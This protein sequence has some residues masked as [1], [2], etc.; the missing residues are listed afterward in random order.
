MTV[1]KEEKTVCRKCGSDRLRQDTDTLDTWFS[2]A[3]WPF[4]TLGWPDK[5][6]DFDYFYPTDTLVTAYEIIFFWVVRMMFSGLEHTGEVPFKTVFIHGLF[7]DS[8]GRKMSKSL[9][10]GIDPL[11]VIDQYGADALRFM[12]ASGNSPG[13]DMR[14][15]E[16]KVR[17]ARGFANKLWNAAR[18]IIM[19]L[20]ENLNTDLGGIALT[21][22]DKW[23]ISKLNALIKEVTENLEKFELGI[24]AGKLYDFIWD[25]Y[26]DWYIELTKPRL[27]NDR[28]N[29]CAVLLRVMKDM[30]KLLHP[31]MPFITEEIWQ[32]LTGGDS[33]LMLEPFP[34][35][36]AEMSFAQEEND[37]SKIVDLIKS[38]RNMRSQM[39]IPPSVKTNL[40]VET[41]HTEL[42]NS[43]IML[44]ER[45]AYAK[46]VKIVTS[47]ANTDGSAVC[48]TDSARAFIPM[49]ELTDREKELE[50]LNREKDSVQKDIDFLTQ[51]L[52]NENFIAKAP[53]HL[54]DAEKA[55]LKKAQ[56]RMENILLSMKGTQ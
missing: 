1:T 42:F 11:D 25:I 4:S 21:A 28:E 20:P 36:D 19:N 49:T 53:P 29:A 2:S 18:Y 15:S 51:K 37:F 50:R 22:E 52:G 32:S 33:V 6:E 10:N 34:V 39:N 14:H 45:L 44:L 55:K 54:V 26:C 5:T 7:R 8:Q 16:E 47:G 46:D 40:T 35:Y 56:E 41:Q 9:G 24:A 13:N 43:A 38:I 48:V 17:S 31:F 23:V 30:L 12:L 3:L 27:Q